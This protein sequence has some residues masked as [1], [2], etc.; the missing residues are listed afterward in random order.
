V[1]LIMVKLLDYWSRHISLRNEERW[2]LYAGSQTGNQGTRHTRRYPA[3]SR[4]E[5]PLP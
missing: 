1:G 4:H 2:Q 3:H 5:A